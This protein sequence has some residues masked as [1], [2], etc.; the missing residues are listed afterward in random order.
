M[1]R[2]LTGTITLTQSGPYF[3]KRNLKEQY[4]SLWIII[5]DIKN[6]VQSSTYAIRKVFINRIAVT[7]R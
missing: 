3:E 5:L 1:N 7:F 6:F 4:L 2:D